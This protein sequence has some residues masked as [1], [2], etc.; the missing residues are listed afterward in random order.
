MPSRSAA[1]ALAGGSVIDADAGGL[2]REP[3][4]PAAFVRARGC[5][6]AGGRHPQPLDAFL[7]A[8]TVASTP[9]V[10]FSKVMIKFAPRADE[11]QP[12]EMECDNDIAVCSR[13]CEKLFGER[14]A[15][16]LEPCKLAVASHFTGSSCFPAG[17]TVQERRRGTIHIA[18][19]QVGDEVGAACGEFSRVV[20][21]LHS[22]ADALVPYLRIRHAA[23][24]ICLSP[25]HLIRAR[26]RASPP[27]GGSDPPAC[28]AAPARGGSWEWTA[29]QN[30]RPGD[31]LLDAQGDAAGVDSIQPA[32]LPGMFAPLTAVGTLLVDG[33]LCSCYAPPTAWA[34]PHESCHNSML[35]LRLLDAARETLERWS[36]IGGARKPLLTLQVLWLL[37]LGDDPTMHPYAS[38]LRRA[39]GF[40][41]AALRRLQALVGQKT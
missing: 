28:A 24:E 7:G 21:L 8:R 11:V 26:R 18:S 1:D 32:R 17:A 14:P 5:H 39:T 30:L 38:G 41:V 12:Q 15:A 20:A 27:G 22:G 16:M 35:P 3:L 4:P 34:V 25:E 33:V 40:G 10:S 6:A 23:G 2:A 9:F 13:E 31:E 19:V 29:A 37:P 36:R